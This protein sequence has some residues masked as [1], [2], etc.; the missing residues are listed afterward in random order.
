VHLSYQHKSIIV[1]ECIR[2]CFQAIGTSTYESNYIVC[3]KCFL[4][5]DVCYISYG[6][7]QTK[8]YK[9]IAVIVYARLKKKKKKLVHC[10][11]TISSISLR[12][13]YVFYRDGGLIILF[14]LMRQPSQP[15]RYW[16][17]GCRFCRYRY[18]LVHLVYEMLWLKH[19]ATVINQGFMGSPHFG[20]F[21]LWLV[22]YVVYVFVEPVF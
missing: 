14:V 17:F 21:I 3:F 6:G 11:N 15:C 13:Q 22:S 7:F 12:S 16:Y 10:E 9:L 20:Y 2:S 5:V 8:V 18:W 19:I 1:G 4:I